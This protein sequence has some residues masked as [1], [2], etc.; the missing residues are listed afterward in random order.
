MCRFLYLFDSEISVMCTYLHPCPC[1]T[2]CC[3]Y[4]PNIKRA[5]V[6]G[7][8]EN[9]Q[10]VLIYSSYCHLG[11]THEKLSPAANSVTCQPVCETVSACHTIVISAYNEIIILK[12]IRCNIQTVSPGNNIRLYTQIH[13]YIVIL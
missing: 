6:S 11:I 3:G 1:I 7:M 8:C 2:A 5:L 13:L 12:L 9:L 10:P 4:F